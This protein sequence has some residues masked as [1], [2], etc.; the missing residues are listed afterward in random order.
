MLKAWYA[1]RYYLPRPF[2]LT[3]P[4]SVQVLFYFEGQSID[5]HQVCPGQHIHTHTCTQVRLRLRLNVE[6][7]G[8]G[9]G[10]GEGEGYGM[11]RVSFLRLT[12]FTLPG[13]HARGWW[14]GWQLSDASI[15]GDHPTHLECHTH[16]VSLW[17]DERWQGEGSG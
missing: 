17:K 4:N 7:E 15:A 13:H 11:V 5:W 6:S 1:V 10:D 14:P 2:E 9:K 3:P 16:G 8:E 12:H